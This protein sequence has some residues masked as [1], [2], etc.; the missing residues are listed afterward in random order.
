MF[1]LIVD[2]LMLFSSMLDL[3]CMKNSDLLGG[4]WSYSFIAFSC[5]MIKVKLLVKE[6]LLLF[7]FAILIFSGVLICL[8]IV[9]LFAFSALRMLVKVLYCPCWDLQGWFWGFYAVVECLQYFRRVLELIVRFISYLI[10]LNYALNCSHIYIM[11][12]C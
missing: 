8:I 7:S 11:V 10:L 9:I 12:F 6:I 2:A 3:I 5:P 4:N 1:S